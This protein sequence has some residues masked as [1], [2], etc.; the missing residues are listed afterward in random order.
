MFCEILIHNSNFVP[1]RLL[2][3]DPTQAVTLPRKDFK[4][5]AEILIISKFIILKIFV[6]ALTWYNFMEAFKR[7]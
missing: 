4:A 5:E 3:L 6:E 7:N 2:V 1:Y